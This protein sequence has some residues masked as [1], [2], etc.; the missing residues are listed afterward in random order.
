MVDKIVGRAAVLLIL[1]AG[2]VESHS[3]II[4]KGGLELFDK[5]GIEYSYLEKTEQIKVKNGEICCPFER[6]IKDIEDPSEA[7][8]VIIQKFPNND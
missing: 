5:Y 8:K 2:A 7:Y 4:S 1:H 3:I 6:M